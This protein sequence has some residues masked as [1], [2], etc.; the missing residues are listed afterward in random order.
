V[1]VSKA[2]NKDMKQAI[3]ILVFILMAT[4]TVAEQ[5]ADSSDTT[6]PPMNRRLQAAV[7]VWEDYVEALKAGDR[8]KAEGFW[9][10]RTKRRYRAFDWQLPDFEKAVDLA[11]NDRMEIADVIEHKDHI[12]LRARSSRSTYT[13]HLIR[14]RGRTLLANPIEV[15]TTGW[16][17]RETKYFVLHY[18]NGNGPTPVQLEDLD[19]FYEEMSSRLTLTL[20]PRI[21]Y[22]KCDSGKDVGKLFGMRPATGRSHYKNHV[23]AATRWTSFHEVA[24]VFFGQLCRKQPVSLILEGAACCYGGTS[25]MSKEAQRCWAKSLVV[26]NEHLPLSHIIQEDGFWSAEDM[27]DSYAEA[28]SFVEFL[29]ST[30]GI[31][32]FKELY[33]YRDT[34]ENV[35]T[36]LERVYER[37]IAELEDEWRAWLLR[38]DVREL[39]VGGGHTAA[40]MFR[41]D[42]AAGDDL[43]DGDYTYPLGSGYEEGMFDLT[44]FR[45]SEEGGR[46]YFELKYRNLAEWEET[47]E[48]GFG[49]TYTRIAV[50]CRG[51]GGNDFGRDAR[52]TLSGNRDY[53]IN[54]S[55]YGVLVWR[56]GRVV[57]LLKRNPSGKKLGDAESNRIWFSIPCSV[58]GI[59]Q[60]SWR[61][62]VA[63][64]G[65]RDGGKHLRDGAGEFLEVG[66][67]PSE[68]TGGGGLDTD[69]NPNIYDVLL[70]PGID[71]KRILGAYDPGTGRHVLLP[72]VGK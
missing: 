10:K 46:I 21:D 57:G 70:A 24:H 14:E 41:M 25:L 38:L 36:E 45:V 26:N 8:E 40:E 3:T 62:A 19:E 9:S 5:T 13:Y 49:G 15:F 1:N 64:G 33:E 66:E 7:S 55:D 16:E 37:G 50:D 61:Y 31:A 17:K 22:Y 68:K 65:C 56:G 71:Q 53:L 18:A 29:V 58:M 11:R 63:V 35:A 59:P 27:N 52:A 48:W 30:Y 12:E 32:R 42:D 47:S 28:A 51:N 39:E 20:E 67:T 69:I 6:K 43:G 2:R 60:K 4:A 44:G 72:M 23:V 54:V 34:T